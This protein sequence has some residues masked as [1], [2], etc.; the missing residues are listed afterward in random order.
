MYDNPNCGRCDK[1]VYHAEEKVGGGR[2]WHKLG[3]FTCKDC[4]V[5]LSSTTLA[6]CNEENEIYCKSCYG[7]KK[8]PKGYGYGSGAGT[9]SMDAGQGRFATHTGPLTQ[10]GAG[11]AYLGGNKCPRCNGSVY[12]A[13]EV[14]GAGMS[15]HKACFNCFTCNNKLDS[16]SCQENEGQI[17]CKSCYNKQF[18]PKGYGFGGGAGALTNAQ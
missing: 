14:L 17:Y 11:S 1:K 16:T 7:K 2:S 4:N 12:H 9:L 10:S 18:G 5:L 3:C 6:E 15:W 8:G 13:E